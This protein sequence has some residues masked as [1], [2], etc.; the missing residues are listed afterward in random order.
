MHRK[1][2]FSWRVQSNSQLI[3]LSPNRS[4]DYLLS[5][6]ESSF[7]RWAQAPSI[8]QGPHSPRIKCYDLRNLPIHVCNKPGSGWAGISSEYS[9]HSQLRL[10]IPSTSGSFLKIYWWQG[11]TMTNTITSPSEILRIVVSLVKSPG[12]STV[13]IGLRTTGLI[14]TIQPTKK[15]M[16]KEF[17]E[18]FENKIYSVLK[19]HLCCFAFQRRGSKWYTEFT[20][21]AL[22]LRQILDPVR[23]HTV[24]GYWK[25]TGN[26][27][28]SNRIYQE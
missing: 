21:V 5:M 26:P 24:C 23:K 28:A 2:F 9:S 11:L 19:L 8:C 13:Q 15:N 10:N 12:D 18:L 16:H 17:T 3:L 7:L 20:V 22:T 1:W 25:K 4:Q 6:V 14:K 27:R